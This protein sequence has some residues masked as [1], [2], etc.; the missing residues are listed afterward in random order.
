MVRSFFAGDTGSYDLHFT[1]APGAN[2]HGVLLNGGSVSETITDGDLDS[3]VFWAVT[4]DS[5]SLSASTEF[6]VFMELYAPDGTNLA[7]DDSLISRNS[8]SQTGTY[9]VVVRSFVAGGTGD[10]TLNLEGD[11]TPIPPPLWSLAALALLLAGIAGLRGRRDRRTRSG[12]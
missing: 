1:K 10:Y 6:A 3:Y 11:I 8:L 9:T 5:L 12:S 2:E 4:G 7:D